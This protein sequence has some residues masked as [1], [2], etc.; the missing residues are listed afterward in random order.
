[1]EQIGEKELLL[2]QN[3]AHILEDDLQLVEGELSRLSTLAEVDLAD[4]DLEPEKRVLR[5]AR[6]DSSLFQMQ[7]LLLDPSGSC[8][9]AEP[10]GACALGSRITDPWFLRLATTQRPIIEHGVDDAAPVRV[11]VPI[12][13]NDRFSGAL[14]GLLP[15]ERQARFRDAV[16]IPLAPSGA[17]AVLDERGHPLLSL[18]NDAGARAI[19]R[20]GAQKGLLPEKLGRVW[21]RDSKGRSWLYAYAPVPAAGWG[22]VIRQARDE[23]DDDLDR[24]LQLFS[25]LL[26]L[27]VTTAVLAGWLLARLVT[28]PLLSLGDRVQGITRGELGRGLPPPE[29]GGDEITELERAFHRMDLSLSARDKEIRALA[30]TLEAKV[31]ERTDEL[32]RAQDALLVSN[33]FAAMGK[34]AAAIA[35]ELK[36]AL[37]GLGV[38]VDLL[39]SGNASP[40]RAGAI[41][42]Q[43]R[44]EVARLRDICDNLNLFAGEP[45]LH[46][47][48][49]DLAGLARRSLEILR[50]TLDESAVELRLELGDSNGEPLVVPCDAPKLQSTLVNLCKNALE[51]MS[52]QAF[53]ESLDGPVL[54]RHHALTI[55]GRRVGSEA[56]LEVEDTGAGLD[57]TIVP[58]LFEPFFTTKRTG[59]GLGLAIA[60]KVVEAHGGTLT[61]E[62]RSRGTLFRIALPAV[63]RPAVIATGKEATT[64]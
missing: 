2:A 51:A 35:H 3:R 42:V 18:G 61:A 4:N 41:R 23:L 1:M 48:P 32:R 29:H 30:S 9:W 21:R 39:A 53:G 62:S 57:P 38:A 19:A 36:N 20:E 11:A 10:A 55:R 34:T 17:V 22:V 60:R 31:L 12:L 6:K 5:Y 58:R 27:G 28:S 16:E 59:T 7:I 13:R 63:G 14:V 50:P 64:P 46:L 15:T 33:R 47:S 49:T 56:I 43:V 45:R 25:A 52:P 40:S 26:L 54:E 37:N 8:L 44:E 24:E